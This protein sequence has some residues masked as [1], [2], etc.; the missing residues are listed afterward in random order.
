ML[1]IIELAIVEIAF[2]QVS[3][4]E[5]AREEKTAA[6]ARRLHLGAAEVTVLE[7]A[8]RYFQ[9]R[10]ETIAEIGF[11]EVTTGDSEFRNLQAL[12][13]FYLAYRFV[14][15][16]RLLQET[17]K[18]IGFSHIFLSFLYQPAL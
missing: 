1:S 11:V 5:P 17:I 8:I 15:E 14:S 10:N 18:K 16:N 6:K 9:A 7:R 2:A 12:R 3:A 4:A 13:P